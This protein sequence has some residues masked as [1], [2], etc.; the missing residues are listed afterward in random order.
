MVRVGR[1]IRPHGLRGDVVVDPDT[2]FAE[3]R[4]RNGAAVTATI[5]GREQSLT[6]VSSRPQGNRW[7]VRFAGH[8]SID[9]ADALRGL[10]LWI[11]GEAATAPAGM[12]YLHDLLGCAVVTVDGEAVGEVTVVYT[13]A[14]QTVLGIET[15]SGE[16]LV[17]VV[18]EI[19]REV[20]VEARRI[21]IAP[22]E[23]L[24][25]VN[26]PVKTDVTR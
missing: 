8:E 18:P 13:G 24:L 17:P 12:H 6:I 25:D 26:A 21:V 19:C 23:G 22:P 5:D 15:A 4:F 14:A 2:D 20:D 3:T 9:A 7:V 1:V 10:E 11:A 16:A